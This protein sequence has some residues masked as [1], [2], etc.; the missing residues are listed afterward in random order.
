MFNDIT[1]IANEKTKIKICQSLICVFLKYIQKDSF[2]KEAGG[3]LIGKENKSNENIIINHIS[4]PMPEDERQNDR[5]IR[6]DKNHIELFKM[7]YEKS[8]GT[9]RYIGEWHTHPEAIPHFSHVDLNNW[10]SIS[11]NSNKYNNYYHIIVG[12][13][14]V[15]MWEINNTTLCTRLI[16]TFFWK[17]IGWCEN[18]KAN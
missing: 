16:G 12:R 3:I 13:K 5:F 6:K 9:L 2:S 14:A 4:I 8:E 10:K 18:D 11:G 15:R 17:D 7:L 1:I